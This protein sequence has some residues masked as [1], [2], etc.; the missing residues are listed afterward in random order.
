MLQCGN[1]T[2]VRNTSRPVCR[3]PV[4]ENVASPITGSGGPNENDVK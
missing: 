2:A 4:P 1:A 3:R